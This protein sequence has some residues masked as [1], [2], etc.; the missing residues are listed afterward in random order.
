MDSALKEQV[1]NAMLR[2]RKAVMRFHAGAGVQPGEM[3]ILQRIAKKAS[4]CTHSVYVSDLHNNIFTKPAISQFLNALEN[5]G[6][7]R[8]EIDR[9]DRRK[10][11]VSLT[12]EGRGILDESREKTDRLLEKVILRFGEEKTREF[13]G[14]LARMTDS[15][16]EVRGEEERRA[17]SEG[18]DTVD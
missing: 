3:F 4:D 7:V 2:F 16:E 15:M 8:R 9:S 18:E 14:L 11:T 6:Y 13:L 17:Q 1:G 12:D 5:K 10:I